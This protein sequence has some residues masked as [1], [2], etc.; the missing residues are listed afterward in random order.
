MAYS[1]V[2][3]IWS[4]LAFGM[5]VFALRFFTRW[6]YSGFRGMSYDDLFAVFAVT[7]WILETVSLYTCSAYGN[8][9]NLSVESALA[10]PDSE[11]PRLI[12]GSKLAYCAWIFYILGIWTL[13]G[14]L[15]CL[16][17]R[18]TMGLQQQRFVWVMMVVSVLTFLASLLWHILSCYPTYRAWQIK[19]YPG[20]SCTQRKWNYVII[21][22][23]DVVTDIGMMA[24]P[25][26]MLLRASLTVR[27]KVSL[28]LLFGSGI[29]VM[30]CAVL[31]A[32]YSLVL[33]DDN[34]VALGWAAREFLVAAIVVNAPSIKPI[35]SDF[36]KR[37]TENYASGSWKSGTG[38]NA[39]SSGLPPYNGKNDIENN[40]AITSGNHKRTQAY[41]MSSIGRSQPKSESQDHINTA[42]D[43]D[44]D[45]TNSNIG[46]DG[47]I[48]T[49]EFKVSRR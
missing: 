30:I 32:Y 39:M 21:C 37:L 17:N 31:R 26:P 9:I 40:T 11:V 36:K 6:K 16:Y 25:I 27:R 3:E 18:L 46:K 48:V 43:A 28:V 13:K 10:V 33:I 15:L 7:F 20:E 19:P 34:T 38:S 44:N 24:I 45:S 14:V 47:I 49:T 12:L 5:L 22:V 8:N 23:L 4:E 1:L 41:K 2:A 35:F 42:T 29:F